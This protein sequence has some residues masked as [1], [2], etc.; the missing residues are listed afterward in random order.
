MAPLILVLAILAVAQPPLAPPVVSGRSAS[1][2][3]RPLELWHSMRDRERRALETAVTAW[4]L[5]NEPQIKPLAFEAENFTARI[6]AALRSGKGPD[7]FIWAH[8]K[9][10]EWAESGFIADLDRRVDSSLAAEYLPNCLEAVEWKGKVRGLPLAF[11]TLILYYNRRL[12]SAPPVNTDELI[13][14]GRRLTDRESGEYGLVYER[15]NFYHHGLWLHGFGGRVFDASGRFDPGSPA[16]LRSLAFARDLGLVHG[17]VPDTVDWN[18]QMSLFNAGRAGLLISGPWAWG[19]IDHARV[20]VG[21]ALL[22]FITEAGRWAAPFM[23]VKAVYVSARSSRPGEA[24]AA[25][26]F[27]TS[28]YAGSVMNILAG[29]LPANRLAY[30]NSVVAGDT[31]TAFFKEQ[32]LDA[33]PMPSDPSMRLVW[34]VMMTDNVTK[35]FGC[36]DRVFL[37]RVPPALAAAEALAEFRRRGGRVAAPAVAA[38]A[39]PPSVTAAPSPTA[40]AGRPGRP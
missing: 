9:T 7:L 11:E 29:A 40:A 35:R 16:M 25:A 34:K 4:N 32:I 1:A 3:R 22:P 33:V 10:G 6:E 18:L 14:I 8:D 13:A 36:L 24:F 23:G 12:V 37:D 19:A 28:G 39:H 21:M 2:T 15:G 31:L 20:N 26:R 38:S 5:E 27:L 30:Q 17:I